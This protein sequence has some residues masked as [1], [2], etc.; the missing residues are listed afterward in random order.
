MK[1]NN[2]Q[3]KAIVNLSK[4][5]SEENP[6]A[7]LRKTSL[8]KIK[9][10]IDNRKH[11]LLKKLNLPPR[12]FHNS[13]LL[14]LGCGSGQNTICYDWCGA[15]CTLVEYEKKSFKNARDL[16]KK[17]SKNKFKTI[18][19]DLFEFKSK[20]KFD[21]VVLNGVAHHTYDA[22]K[23]IEIAIKYLNKGGMI[24][25]G[26]GE[27][28]GF[29]QKHFQ[30]HILY[31]LS[32]DKREIVN[33]SKV[34]FRE[35]LSRAKKFGGRSES[36]IIYDT[37]LNP[38][39]ETL[40]FNQIQKLFHKKKVYL[41]S[42]DEENFD[43]EKLYDVQNK[44]FS[45]LS[46]ESGNSNR[47]NFSLNSI[48]NFSLTKELSLNTKSI[49][50]KIS[51]ID[52]LQNKLTNIVNNQSIKKFKIKNFDYYLKKYLKEIKK[53]EK[54][55]LIDKTSIIQFISE[56]QKILKILKIKNKKQKII[57]LKVAIK[58]SKRLFKKFSGKG[59]NYFVGLSY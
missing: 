16:F 3:K 33:L 18:N 54:V 26:I 31:S 49:I 8:N 28:N 9:I 25:L 56:I 32:K 7:Y 5:Y 59:M 57:K 20:K 30:R 58:K 45:L 36:E 22:K 2:K 14:D 47:Y 43:L 10:F 40:N 17:F 48:N 1:Y 39:I 44:Q 19:K 46:K 37:Y 13:S 55:S 6:S 34:L 23:C 53:N 38:K 4:I 12:I 24:I 42:S 11:F 51:K 41:Y 50:K 52:Y 35:N 29:F 27:T 21:F 15:E